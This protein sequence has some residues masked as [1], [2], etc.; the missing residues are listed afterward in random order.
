MHIFELKEALDKISKQTQTLLKKTGYETTGQ[1]S[2]VD[3]DP[4]DPDQTFLY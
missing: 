4:A 1:L 2:N 3:L